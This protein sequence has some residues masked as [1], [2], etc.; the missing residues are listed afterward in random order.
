MM[1]KIKERAYAVLVVFLL[2]GIIPASF[3]DTFDPMADSE[4]IMAPASIV[5]SDY[6]SFTISIELHPTEYVDAMATDL[7]TFDPAIIACQNISWGNLFSDETVQVKGTIDNTNGTIKYMV[8]GAINETNQNG[9]YANFTFDALAQGQ[10]HIS[11]N[12]SET[13]LAFEGASVPY[14][15]S[16]NVTVNVSSYIPGPPSGFTATPSNRTV[17]QLDWTKATKADYTWIEWNTV[18]SWDRGEG[19]FITNTS[20]TNINDENL[21][22]GETR[23]YRGWSY[24]STGNNWSTTSALDSATTEEN[25]APALSNENPSNGSTV[26]IFG[27]I[28]WSIDINDSEGDAFNWSIECSDGTNDSQTESTNDTA[29]F[30]IANPTFGTTYMLWVNVTDGY[31][32]TREWY[33]VTMRNQYVPDPPTDLVATKINLTAINLTWTKNLSADTTYIEV[34][35]EAPWDFGNGSQ[36]YNGTGKQITIDG[37]TPDHYYFQA[38]SYN[39]TDAVYSSTYAEADVLTGVNTPVWQLNE[40]PTNGSMDIDIL[41]PTVNIT[42][43]DNES[44]TISYSIHSPYL[45][46][47]S[48]SGGNNTYTATLNTP[49]P[50]DT[51]ITWYVN[52]TDGF[53]WTNATYSFTTRTQY[54]PNAPSDIEVKTISPEQIN[55]SWVLPSNADRVIIETNASGDWTELY[56]NSGATYSHTGLEGHTTYHYRISAYNITD[57]TQ[58]IYVF[59]YNTTDNTLASGIDGS[60]STEWGPD[61]E[62]HYTHIYNI[63]LTINVSDPDNDSMDVY[64]YWADGTALGF[65]GSIASGTVVDF[66]T[67][68]YAT[69]LSYWYN[70]SSAQWEPRNFLNQSLRGDPMSGSTEIGGG[71]NQTYTWYAIIDD[72]YD[73]VQTQNYS[74]TT[75]VRYDLNSDGRMSPSDISYL[76]T[77]YGTEPMEPGGINWADITEDGR[78]SATDISF[79]LAN[80]GQDYYP[81]WDRS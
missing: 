3:A 29:F 77:Y 69:N 4:I 6:D 28:D 45:T 58:S 79:F 27:N 24:N 51:L 72:G 74:F 31:D 67:T 20:G 62:P 38:W 7:I 55:I 9:I 73:T 23:Y 16:N 76:L 56:N 13:G 49:L 59:E 47:I 44:D 15:I 54:E 5:C 61:S 37:L 12:D 10:T 64:F 78:T 36:V 1:K 60:V 75:A 46:N 68:Q 41:Q 25:I 32:W 18:A 43:A 63:H 71:V 40:V 50:Y 66:N 11:I 26:E 35:S 2:I 52:A 30:T 48:G 42:V 81:D 57:G 14:N 22:P 8:W 34:N 39:T 70:S 33:T 17:I 53:E 21:L 80:Y 65:I 19:T